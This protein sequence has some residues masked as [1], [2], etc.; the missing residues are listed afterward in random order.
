MVLI[1]AHIDCIGLRPPRISTGAWKIALA[2]LLL[3][4]GA[5]ANFWI[6]SR[7][8]NQTPFWDQ[9]DGEGSGLYI[10]FFD[11]K[12][13]ISHFFAPHNEHR[14]LPT[15]LLALSLIELN[16]LW[17][18]I[19]QMMVN[20]IIHVTVGVFFLLA[21]RQHLDARAYSGLAILVLIITAVPF[22]VESTLMGFQTHFYSLLLFGLIAI[23]L[24]SR[25]RSFSWKWLVGFA[26]AALSYLSLASGGLIFFASF[27]ILLTKL[28]LRV[29][30]SRR[31]WLGAALL[32]AGFAVALLMTPTIEGHAPLKAQSVSQFL[33]AFF[34]LSGW[35][36]GGLAGWRFGSNIALAMVVYIPV[37]ALMVSCFRFRP[38]PNSIVWPI[39]GMGSW[40]GL[41]LAAIAYG[42]A[43]GIE[44]PRYLDIV[45]VGLMV[46]Y[47][48]AALLSGTAVRK[49][50]AAVWAILVMVGL[51][52]HAVRVVP[53]EL[54]IY[55]EL[56]LAQEKNVKAFLET[57]AFPLGAGDPP[58]TLPYPNPDRL[59]GLLSNEKV[60]RFLPSNLQTAIPTT[61]RPG[62]EAGTD[63]FGGVRDV[64]LK[65]SGA[66]AG[67]SLFLFFVLSFL[68][69]IEKYHIPRRRGHLRRPDRQALP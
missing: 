42:R 28:I 34:R 45:A 10:P 59:A 13:T 36:L 27:L 2:I 68:M 38:A 20:A 7:Y 60:R 8:G 52:I 9:W 33:H 3:L 21:F 22:A 32:L 39:L 31:E 57:G 66:V 49:F 41:Q 67:A 53:R 46:N 44:A 19:L 6:V 58:L 29:E 12:L 56:S 30:G 35:P 40:V 47:I 61:E 18:P 65:W 4:T 1:R 24:M 54:K 48:S 69:L 51:V 63:H 16:G 5:T 11:S 25:E 62:A 23:W 37:V 55:Q 15:R 14:I 64:L 50:V 26:A 43:V 17:D